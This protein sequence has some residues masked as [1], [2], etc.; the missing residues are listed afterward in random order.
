MLHH[1]PLT[2][3]ENDRSVWKNLQQDSTYDDESKWFIM[4]QVNESSVRHV[5]QSGVKVKWKKATNWSCFRFI[6]C[7]LY[8]RSG[9]DDAI[10]L[11]PLHCKK[12]LQ[13][14]RKNNHI[15]VLT[16][17]FTVNVGGQVNHTLKRQ[18]GFISVVEVSI[19]FSTDA[20]EKFDCDL[21]VLVVVS[22]GILTTK[23]FFGSHR[24][25]E[26]MAIFETFFR[27]VVLN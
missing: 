20:S 1:F 17:V 25:C 13:S 8:H 3:N 7:I 19:F 9:T 5:G 26:S 14:P 27:T 4:I 16:S 11:I 12:H 23:H 21:G 24:N 22:N 2:R 18:R 10:A 15:F 6:L